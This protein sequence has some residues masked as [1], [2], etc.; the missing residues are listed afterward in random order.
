MIEADMEL[1]AIG[2]TVAA[3]GVTL[4]VRIANGELRY[5]VMPRALG[6]TLMYDLAIGL[7]DKAP[8]WP[9]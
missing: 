8:G 9:V 3:Y 5:I 4:I 2:V 7:Q 1:E 6:E